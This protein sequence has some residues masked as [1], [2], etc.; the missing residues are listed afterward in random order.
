MSQVRGEEEKICIY[1]HMDVQY[2]LILNG[3]KSQTLQNNI[4]K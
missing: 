3:C 4:H 1:F 2:I